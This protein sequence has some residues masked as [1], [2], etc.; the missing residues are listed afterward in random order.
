MAKNT[1]RS[2][3]EIRADLARNRAQFAG[4]VGEL[5]DEVKPKNIAKR[6]VASAKEF[7]ATEF[8]SVKDQ[9]RDE[10]GWRT[11]RLVIIGGAVLS[12]VVFAITLNSIA[13]ARQRSLGDRARE[14][15]MAIGE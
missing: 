5:I 15:I 13:N 2:V 9:V 4:S 14:A 6:G 1:A 12:V 11:D 8:A 10:H 7:A 3:D